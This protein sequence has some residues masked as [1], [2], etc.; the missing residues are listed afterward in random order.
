MWLKDVDLQI[1][2]GTLTPTS[3]ENQVFLSSEI[4]E[5]N[6]GGATAQEEV[7]TPLAI[8]SH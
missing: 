8:S 1:D 6:N 7:D 4:T 2:A 5:G 3:R